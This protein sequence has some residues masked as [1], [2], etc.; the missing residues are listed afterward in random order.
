M[1]SK[2][3][4]STATNTINYPDYDSVSCYR[5]KNFVEGGMNVNDLRINKPEM[6]LVGEEG[7]KYNK[8]I[9]SFAS[10]YIL[11]RFVF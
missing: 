7:Y 3:V 6:L 11:S 2:S 1:K 9:N 8:H 5:G 4:V 10:D